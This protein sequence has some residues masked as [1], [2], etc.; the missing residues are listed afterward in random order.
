MISGDVNQNYQLKYSGSANDRG[1]V[2]QRIV[3]I[4]GSTSITTTIN[5]YYPEDI[6][7]DGTIKYSGSNN[8]PS[9][10]IQ[11]LVNL[12]GSTSITTVFII[13]VPQGSP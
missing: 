5:G 6:N 4:S 8:D 10:I 3:S 2:L 7:M 12:T 11:N 13:P 1:L 9:I